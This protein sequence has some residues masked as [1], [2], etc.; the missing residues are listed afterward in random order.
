MRLCVLDVT[1]SIGRYTLAVVR[2][3]FNPQRRYGIQFPERLKRVPS[4]SS[5]GSHGQMK[6]EHQNMNQHKQNVKKK[7]TETGTTTPAL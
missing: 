5:I 6:Y 1:A 7:E 4:V 3:L 2:R